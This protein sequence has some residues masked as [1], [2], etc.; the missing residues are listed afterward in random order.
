MSRNVWLTDRYGAQV[1]DATVPRLSELLGTIGMDDDTE[2]SS[3]SLTDEDE[4]NLEFY[5]DRVLFENVGEE[6]EPVGV[7]RGSTRE[8]QVEMGR[9][10][11]EGRLDDLRS[12]NWS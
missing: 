8:D 5:P 9:A 12:R 3:V 11:I 4:W 2:H 6:G 7:I 1:D 10:F